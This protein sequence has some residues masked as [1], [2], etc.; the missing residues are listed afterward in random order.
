MMFVS[1]IWHIEIGYDWVQCH[2]RVDMEAEE[3][4]TVSELNC[5]YREGS[6]SAMYEILASIL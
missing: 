1:A 3:L 4:S 5:E 6:G 2:R